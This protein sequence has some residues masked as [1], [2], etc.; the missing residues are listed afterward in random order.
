MTPSTAGL[1]EVVVIGYG[2]QRKKEVTASIASVKSENFVKG[3]V[4]T[5]YEVEFRGDSM[6]Q[7][8]YT[9]KYNSVPSAVLHMAWSSKPACAG[10]LATKPATL[11]VRASTRNIGRSGPRVF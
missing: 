7:K 3:A 4:K 6:Y 8:A 1:E 11:R 2:T 10:Y 5:F 9:N